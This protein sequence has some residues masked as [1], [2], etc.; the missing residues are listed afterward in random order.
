MPNSGFKYDLSKLHRFVD[1]IPQKVREVERR[2]GQAAVDYAVE[3]GSYHD[4]TGRLRASNRFEADSDGL[5]LYNT[6][7]YAADV[8]SS[9]KEVLSGAALLAERMLREECDDN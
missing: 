5:S 9:G 4:V 6:A 1:S 7:P 8:E 3:H 2:V